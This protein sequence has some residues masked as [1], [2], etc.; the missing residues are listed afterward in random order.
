MLFNSLAFAVFLPVVF[1]LYW[2]CTGGSVRFQNL[3]LLAASYFFYGCWDYRFLFLLLFSTGL[4][5]FTGLKIGQATT[6]TTKKN[7]LLLSIIINLGLLG[8]FKYYN[9]FI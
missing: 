3:L 1:G 8:F 9:F 7:W 2:F 5:Y 4:D 6:K